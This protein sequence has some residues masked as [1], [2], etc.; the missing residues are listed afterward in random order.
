MQ[1]LRRF[2]AFTLIELLVVIA[3]IAILAAMLLPALAAAREK[4]RRS[5]CMNNL[6][7]MGKAFEMY[8]SAYGQYYPGYLDWAQGNIAPY[9][10]SPMPNIYTQAYTDTL[11]NQTVRLLDGGAQGR[12]YYAMMHHT[13]GTGYI[14]IYGTAVPAAGNLRVAPH[15]MG[16]L[17]VTGDLPDEKA[18]YCPSGMDVR[19]P[20]ERYG[21]RVNDTLGDWKQAR[22]GSGGQ[23]AGRVLTNGAWPRWTD[24]IGVYDNKVEFNVTMQYAYRNQAI[25]GAIY[26][27]RAPG[28]NAMDGP[29]TMPWCKGMVKSEVGAPPFKTTKLLGGRAL[30][31][32]DF[33]RGAK[34]RDPIDEPDNAAVDPGY[35]M[36]T[37]RDGYNVLYGDGGA[38]W[39]GD[40]EQKI[41]W[42]F[43]SSTVGG[44]GALGMTWHWIGGG[45]AGFP[46]TNTSPPIFQKFGTPAIWHTF[47]D[48][49][50]LDSGAPAPY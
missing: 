1:V 17:L 45:S 12:T 50:G 19:R 28:Y 31:S 29:K 27:T 10:P 39:Y 16:T 44:Y 26:Y 18:L 13:L 40:P 15:N 32:D 22:G 8:T 46:W 41:I 4:A 34:G 35:C 33:W 36:Y 5:S 30:V 20:T 25:Y 9:P 47:D 49:R 23:E 21:H 48:A 37:H 24:S 14:G 43:D 38:A 2:W 3:I 6:N 7:Q 42:W 11:T